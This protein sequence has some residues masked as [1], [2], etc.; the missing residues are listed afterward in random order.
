METKPLGLTESD[1]VGERIAQ[2]GYIERPR[3]AHAVAEGSNTN[4]WKTKNKANPNVV[5]GKR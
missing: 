2:S 3:R 4:A 1:P 5:S